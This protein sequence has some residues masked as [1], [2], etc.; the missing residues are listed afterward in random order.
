MWA[1]IWMIPEDKRN[2]L[3]E[4][5]RE[6]FGLFSKKKKTILYDAEKV[7]PVLHKSICTG[8][9][10]AGFRELTGQRKYREVMLIRSSRDLE[11]FME[12]YGIKEIP[13]TEY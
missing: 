13:E 6:M 10:T 9:T 8:E 11:E 5:K 1:V 12:T 4:R 2:F 7:K 3:E